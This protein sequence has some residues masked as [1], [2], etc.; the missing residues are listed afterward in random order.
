MSLVGGLGWS[1]NLRDHSEPTGAA[2]RRTDIGTARLGLESRPLRRGN[3]RLFASASLAGS[4]LW[5]EYGG[6]ASE[7][8]EANGGGWVSGIYGLRAQFGAPDAPGLSLRYEIRPRYGTLAS[9]N[10]YFGIGIAF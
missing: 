8:G 9:F 2:T 1:F 3:A 6:S 5:H 7:S 10:P 4:W